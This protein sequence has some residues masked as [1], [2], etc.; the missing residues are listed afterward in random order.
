M[1][2]VDVSVSKQ[3]ILT[4]GHVK[5]SVAQNKKLQVLHTSVPGVQK[6]EAASM[7]GVCVFMP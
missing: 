1:R 2:K 4:L 5:V 6:L 3:E 7:N